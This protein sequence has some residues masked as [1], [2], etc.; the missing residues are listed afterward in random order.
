MFSAMFEGPLFSESLPWWCGS[1]VVCLAVIYFS[2][3]IAPWGERHVMPLR[4][5][6][7][8]CSPVVLVLYL[9]QAAGLG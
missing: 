5:V 3:F 7:V 4:K 6:V 1:W 8:G 9:V 2:V